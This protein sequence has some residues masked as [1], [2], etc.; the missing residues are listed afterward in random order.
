MFWPNM[1]D[2]HKLPRGTVVAFAN[3]CF[4]IWVL[5]LHNVYKFTKKD[6]LYLKPDDVVCQMTKIFK[7]TDMTKSD[8][9]FPYSIFMAS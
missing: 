4:R 7:L 9:L 8:F 5:F 1:K 6:L 3:I 2:K